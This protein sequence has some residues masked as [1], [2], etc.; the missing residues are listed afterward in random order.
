MLFTDPNVP[1]T[2]GNKFALAF[3][4]NDEGIGL[5]EITLFVTTQQNESS[6]TIE[7]LIPGLGGFTETEPE[8][9]IYVRNGKAYRGQYTSIV[10]QAGQITRNGFFDISVLSNGNED[11]FDRQKGFFISGENSQDELTVYAL[12]TNQATTGSFMAISCRQ[13][14]TRHYEYFIFAA[15]SVNFADSQ[16]LITP[17]ED[18]TKITV[19]PSQTHTHPLWVRSQ[20]LNTNPDTARRT[21][22]TY[23]RRLRIFDTIMLS[24]LRDLTGTIIT[25]TKPL[26]V[27]TGHQ[28]GGLF[29]GGICDFMIEQIP[30]HPTYGD[31]FLLAPFDVRQSGEVYRIG[32]VSDDIVVEINCMCEPRT[33]RGNRVG[34]TSLGRTHTAVLNRGEYIECETP[35]NNRTFCSVQS[36]R[37]VTVMSYTLTHLLDNLGPLP[38]LPFNSIG[39]PSIVYIPPVLSYLTQY[40]LTSLTQDYPLYFSYVSIDK[41]KFHSLIVNN[42][43][44]NST[45]STIECSMCTSTSVCGHGGFGY[46]GNGDFTISGQDLFWGYAYGFGSEVSYASPL[47]FKQVPIGCKLTAV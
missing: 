16:L 20:F 42:E 18:S 30:S 14:P 41:Q 22:S 44:F 45:R 9:E 43:M 24:N 34:L 28:C 31:M 26:S 29:S 4:K 2:R 46:L 37:P 33:L 25:S 36:S 21:E 32:A 23:G 10:L 3:M 11:I 1:T 13:F 47:P 19:A 27:F 38:N 35:K 8:S 17:C 7:T 5:P 40:S 15:A 39:S 6:F 12:S